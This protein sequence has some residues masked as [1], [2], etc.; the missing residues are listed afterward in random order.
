[1]LRKLMQWMG[2]RPTPPSLS[3]DA[4][5]LPVGAARGPAPLDVTDADFAAIALAAGLPVVVDFWAEWCA[6]CEVVSAYTSFLAR[7]Y[8]ERIRVV[9]LDVDEN[10]ATPAAYAVMGLP[11]LLFL[12]DGVEVGRHVGLL[13]YEELKVKVDAL[14]A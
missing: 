10:P 6:P 7:D 9:A 1:M 3:P 14:L 5:P 4:R 11:T 12:R 13:S 8:A 2:G